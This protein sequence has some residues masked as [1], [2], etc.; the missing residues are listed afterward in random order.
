MQK[1][2]YSVTT[3]HMFKKNKKKYFFDVTFLTI[4]RLKDCICQI[5]RSVRQN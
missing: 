3:P 2:N 1:G 4:R 5:I